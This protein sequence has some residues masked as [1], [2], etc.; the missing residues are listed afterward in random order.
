MARPARKLGLLFG[1]ASTALLTVAG[2]WLA[3][4]SFSTTCGEQTQQAPDGAITTS[5]GCSTAPSNYENDG[6]VGV[7]WLG[8]PALLAIAALALTPV[9]RLR[10]PARW[11]VGVPVVLLGLLTVFTPF[12]L[13]LLPAGGLMVLAAVYADDPPAVEPAAAGLPG[14]RD[15]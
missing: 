15:G 3:L 12:M 9:A 7:L 1:A 11:A 13:L 5:G 4:G 8:L 14:A 2:L 10:A 6:L